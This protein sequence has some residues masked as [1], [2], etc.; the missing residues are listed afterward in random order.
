MTLC[1]IFCAKYSLKA[2]FFA[3]SITISFSLA[4]SGINFKLYVN[5]TDKVYVLQSIFLIII[6][7]NHSHYQNYLQDISADHPI[8][9]RFVD[10]DLQTLSKVVP[11]FLSL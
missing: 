3:S 2:F 6:V 5:I 4:S 9:N 8:K 11:I 1:S 10:I 7:E